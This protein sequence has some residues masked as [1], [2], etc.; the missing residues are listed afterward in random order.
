MHDPAGMGRL[1][2][3]LPAV[4][5]DPSELRLMR[6]LAAIM[7]IVG[8]LTS[9]IGVLTVQATPSG[10]E[11]QAI[12]AALTMSIG[13]MVLLVPARPGVFRFAVIASTLLVSGMMA[14]AQPISD[15]EFF[16]LW[17]VVFAAYFLG[18]RFTALTQ[19]VMM[20]GLG[21]GLA[22]THDA[23]VKSDVFTSTTASVGLIGCLVIVMRTRERRLATSLAVAART[24][25]LT[26][27]LNRHGL[28]P[29]LER[30]VREAQTT[31]VPLALALFDLDHFKWFNDAHGHLEGDEALRRVGLILRGSA[32]TDD[33]VARYGGE[34]FAVLLPG[35]TAE[36]AYSY[37]DRV[38]A[39]LGAE[40]VAEELRL[41]ASCG[42]AQVQPDE[43]I[44]AAF[45]RADEALYAAK[46]HGRNRAAWWRDGTIL[47]GQPLES[48]A[49]A[50]RN[51]PPQ[52]P[53]KFVVRLADRPPVAE[54]P[55][56]DERKRA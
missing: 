16:Y 26:G 43:S 40:D 21:I 32:R 51:E 36:G 15:T 14:T 8:A 7:C 31:G 17:P 49:R 25:A 10:R 3:F 29:E 28:E 48:I 55:A 2:Q 38:A 27:L 52:H 41:T 5:V 13:F 50:L 42:I 47:V 4:P 12:L 11:S 37:A 45:N 54:Y 18:P 9:F 30:L 22:L 33:C 24:D 34:E 53:R 6:G 46:H 20:V 35:A 39:G 56:V 44:D 1:D 23:V 19:L